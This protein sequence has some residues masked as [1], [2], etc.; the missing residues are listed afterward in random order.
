ML[1]HSAISLVGTLWF[2]S[3]IR[4]TFCT[5]FS[6]C[7]EHGHL[8]HSSSSIESRLAQNHLVHFITA[9]Q[10]WA[11]V[12]Q[13]IALTK[14]KWNSIKKNYL[15]AYKKRF[16]INLVLFMLEMTTGSEIHAE[17]CFATFLQMC[18][19]SAVSALRASTIGNWSCCFELL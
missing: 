7:V 2:I 4:F 16:M 15:T 11:K 8:S 3:T 18:Q 17:H 5:L 1:V 12:R 13:P 14:K 19:S 9:V 10:W 6:L